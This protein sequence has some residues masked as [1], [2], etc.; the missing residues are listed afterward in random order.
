M[1]RLSKVLS[2]TSPCFSRRASVIFL[3]FA[4]FL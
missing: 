2:S 3:T 1:T 4:V